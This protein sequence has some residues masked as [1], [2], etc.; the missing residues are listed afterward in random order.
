MSTFD[1][2]NDTPYQITNEG[3]QISVNFRRTGAN[4]GVVTWNIPDNSAGCAAGRD[5]MY[6]GI[7]IT[8]DTESANNSKAPINGTKYIGDPTGDSM[9]HVGDKLGSAFVIGAFYGDTTTISLNVV[10]LT[11]DVAYFISAH[12]VDN[13]FQYHIEGVHAYSTPYGNGK[14]DDTTAFQNIRVGAPGVGV[15]GTDL[16]GYEPLETYELNLVLDNDELSTLSFAGIDIQTYDDFIDEWNR[17]AMLYG[18]PLQSPTIPNI[19]GYY[20]N[21]TTNELFQ[22]DGMTETQLPVIVEEA[23]P[24]TPSVGDTW[25][26]PTTNILYEWDGAIWNVQLFVTLSHA[27]NDLICDDCWFDNTDVFKWDGTVWLPQILFNQ[28]IDPSLAPD[29]TCS[30]HWFNETTEQLFVWDDNCDE[31][32]LTLAILWDEEP[33]TPLAMQFWFNET[34]DELNQWNGATWDLV[35]VTIATEE[36][37]TVPPGGYWYNPETMELFVESAGPIFTE[38]DVLV[39][40]EDPTTVPSG[41]LWWDGDSDLLYS[42]DDLTSAWLPVTPFFIQPIDP[43]LSPVIEIGSVWYDGTVFYSW[44]G[45]EWT[46]KEIIVSTGDPALLPDGIYWFNTTDDT[47]YELV[48]GTWTA[49]D[50]ID[51]I[52]D[53]EAPAVDDFW[54]KPSTEVL[55]QWD[56]A[57]WNAVVYSTVSLIAT[58]GTR[59]FDT[60]LGVLREWNGFGWVDA[61]PKYTVTFQQ[62]GQQLHLETSLLGSNARIE[63]DF[64]G[65]TTGTGGLTSGTVPP[66]FVVIGAFPFFPQ[67]GGDGL[68]PVPSYE[69]LGVGTDGTDDERRELMDAI[70]HQLGYPTIEVELTKQQLS[71]A[72]DGAIESLRKRSGMAYRRG[73][74]FLE[75][76]PHQQMYKLT[77]KRIGYNRIAEVTKIHRITSAFLS[78]AEGQ[79]VY[80]QLALQH[81][82]QMGTFD[83]ISYHLVSQ[84]IETMEM[85]FASQI[86]FNWDEDTRN[87]GIFKDFHQCEKVLIEVVVERT[88][89]NMIKDRYLKGWIEKY[90]LVQSRLTLAEI[91]GKFAHLPGAGGGVALNASELAARAD[92]DLVDLYE[93]IDNHI[94]NNPEEFGAGSTF[95]LG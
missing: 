83:L 29:L 85:L 47:F 70:R 93:Q 58:I 61:E 41:T 28:A 62:N 2:F 31:W 65:C 21:Q 35:A 92:A 90:A 36:P 8:L 39:W 57:V 68:Q 75:I 80:G 59:Y 46:V 13:V 81:L 5:P 78:N 73:F 88:E 52:T 95:I 20:Y 7:V 17:Q 4:T 38:V 79:G 9:L 34:T 1:Q 89:Q 53:P 44:D 74:Y 10:G 66:M 30:A 18:N 86:E 55:S 48:T 91:R 71:Y 6:D 15:L 45:S 64:V 77:D 11:V 94:T 50:P 37:T 60:T 32:K 19:N 67:R 84:Y 3:I 82:Y 25:Y 49:I 54:Y 24:N 69:Q 16:T 42:W 14:E 63:T 23:Q 26:N 27:P 22:Y 76:Q 12:A 51:S 72:I 56:G 43:S 33:T 87:L 40:S